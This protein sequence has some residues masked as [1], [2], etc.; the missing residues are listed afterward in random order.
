M[1][2]VSPCWVQPIFRALEWLCLHFPNCVF[3]NFSA[4]SML[5]LVPPIGETAD[6]KNRMILI[7]AKGKVM[8]S[9]WLKCIAGVTSSDGSGDL[10]GR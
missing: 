8:V 10:S 1:N 9:S 4:N 7:S 3:L 6:C 5:D 2:T